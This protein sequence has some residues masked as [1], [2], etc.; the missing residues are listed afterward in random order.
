MRVNRGNCSKD[1]T[2]DKAITSPNSFPKCS[3]GN[4]GGQRRF[5]RALG[6]LAPWRGRAL[7]GLGQ[8]PAPIPLG[9]SSHH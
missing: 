4:L 1:T 2:A 9:Y 6:T 5:W 8:P 7:V 3:E